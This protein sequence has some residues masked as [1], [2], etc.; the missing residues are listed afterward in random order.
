MDIKSWNGRVYVYNGV[1]EVEYESLA[2]LREELERTGTP[3][4]LKR[5]LA[6]WEWLAG[7]PVIDKGSKVDDVKVE[8][9]ITLATDIKIIASEEKST[10]TLDIKPVVKHG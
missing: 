6:L 3:A 8:T 4:E 9:R 1:D 5:R 7:N 2:A 10:D